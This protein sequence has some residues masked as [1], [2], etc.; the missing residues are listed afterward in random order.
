MKSLVRIAIHGLALVGAHELYKE[1]QLQKKLND[2][3]N[4][5]TKPTTHETPST[6]R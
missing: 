6:S 2:A 1:Y 5:L 3:V 4:R